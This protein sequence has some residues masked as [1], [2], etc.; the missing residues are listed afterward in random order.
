MTQRGLDNMNKQDFI[1]L[2]KDGAIKGYN[3]YNILPSLTM[4]QAI[5]ETGWGRYLIGNNI[6]GIKADKNWKGKTK[7]IKT[8][9]YVNGKRVYIDAYF[10]DYDSI[11][12]CLEDRFVFLSK[13]RYK[14]VIQAKDYKT[15]CN[16][17]WKAG[18]ATDPQYPQK[19]IKIIEQNKLYEFDN[20]AEQEPSSWSKTSWEW[21]KNKR[22]LDGNRPKDNMTR[23]E[24]AIILQRVTK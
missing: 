4:A 18:Y 17:I 2:I 16:E 1:D 22:L 9:E 20:V 6:F 10:R 24:L 15:A 21:A 7:K 8:H 19:L 23:E 3:A 14:K 11:D 12:D 13:P 5:L